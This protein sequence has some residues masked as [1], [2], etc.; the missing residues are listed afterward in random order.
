MLESLY[1]PPF[2]QPCFLPGESGFPIGYCILANSLSDLFLLFITLSDNSIVV[3][4]NN[5]HLHYNICFLFYSSMDTETA[6]PPIQAGLSHFHKSEKPLE[7][8]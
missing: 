3:H 6:F 8:P 1:L 5:C 7:T 2:W 4:Y